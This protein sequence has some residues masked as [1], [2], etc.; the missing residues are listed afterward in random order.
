MNIIAKTDV[1]V[2]RVVSLEAQNPP[3]EVPR[4]KNNDS[5]ASQNK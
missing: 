1:F 5:E 2:A 3:E 4:G